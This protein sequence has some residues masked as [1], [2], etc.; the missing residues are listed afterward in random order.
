MVLFDD[1]SFQNSPKVRLV[2]RQVGL[3]VVSDFKVEV[4]LSMQLTRRQLMGTLV[5]NGL[6]CGGDGRCFEAS[7][8]LWLEKIPFAHPQLLC[9][10]GYP[11]LPCFRHSESLT[12]TVPTSSRPLSLHL[13]SFLR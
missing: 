4:V 9:R 1:I 3:V 10:N 7:S 8:E 2:R 11:I 12:F 5:V 13:F 6:G